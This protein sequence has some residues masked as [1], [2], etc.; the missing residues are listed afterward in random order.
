MNTLTEAARL[1]AGA[2]ARVT[3]VTGEARMAVLT[4]GVQAGT[5]CDRGCAE[6]ARSARYLGSQPLRAGL[7]PAA[8]TAL[9]PTDG[10]ETVLV[11]AEAKMLR[12]SLSFSARLK[13]AAARLP[14]ST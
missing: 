4:V 7:T 1:C 14:H 5:C 3:S 13:K 12:H 10:G 6:V 9:E 11:G 8:P 2:P